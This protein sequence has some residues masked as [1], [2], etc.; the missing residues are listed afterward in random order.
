MSDFDLYRLSDEHLMLREAVR[1]VCDDKIAPLAAEV[2]ESGEFPQ[3]SYDALRK[4]D[5]HA[6]HIPDE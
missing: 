3:A 1:A 5:F 6:V 2:D 4:A